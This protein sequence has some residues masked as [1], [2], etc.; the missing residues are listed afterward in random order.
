MFM[1]VFVQ[2]RLT[3]LDAIAAPHSNPVPTSTTTHN[4]VG[5]SFMYSNDNL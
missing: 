2:E 3:R 5:C 1:F 4:T